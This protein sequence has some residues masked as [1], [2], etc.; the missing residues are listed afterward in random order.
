MKALSLFFSSLIAACLSLSAAAL[1][2]SAQVPIL[3]YHSTNIAAPCGYAG[4]DMAT[5]AADLITLKS[6][7]IFVVPVYWLVEWALGLRDGS[8]LPD[9]VVGITLD[10]GLD[11]DWNDLYVPGH[12]CG[13]NLKSARTVLT[14]FKNLHP[15]LPWYSPHASSFVIASPVVRSYLGGQYYNDNWWY[16]AQ[17][18]GLMEIYNH[19]TDHDVDA[20]PGY[21]LWDAG[22]NAYVPVGGYADGYWDGLSNFS[23]AAN[24]TVAQL[25][26]VNAANYI[27][28]MTGAYPDLF[29]LPF[30]IRNTGLEN[31]FANNQS[32]HNTLA[33]FG[34]PGGYLS[35]NSERWNLPRLVHNLAWHSPEDFS[36]LLTNA[37]Y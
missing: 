18:S 30:G 25:E 28:G 2:N 6:R 35:R 7:E 37:G 34:A 32:L 24:S 15:E 23:R 11:L 20:T 33:A 13:D 4:D 19:S 31:W 12:D 17:N 5:L 14:E 8:T 26:V 27:G 1:S 21:P 3:L 29:A 36:A 22:I 10:D 9:K 16:A